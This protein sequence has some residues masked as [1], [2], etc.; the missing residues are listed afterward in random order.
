[1]T[2]QNRNEN[3]IDNTNHNINFNFL[4]SNHKSHISKLIFRI[5]QNYLLIHDINFQ[6]Y[7]YYTLFFLLIYNIENQN[8]TLVFQNAISFISMNL[9]F[10][11]LI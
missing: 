9:N 6:S 2:A 4:K 10:I 7:Y 11:N 8:L 5:I 1:M 3:I